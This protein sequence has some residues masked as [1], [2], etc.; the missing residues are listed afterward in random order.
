[1]QDDHGYFDYRSRGDALVDEYQGVE[2]PRGHGAEARV[3]A[4]PQV[5]AG[6]RLFGLALVSILVLLS[7]VARAQI[8]GSEPG[9]HVTGT[10]VVYGEPDTAMLNI[11]VSTVAEDVKVAMATSDETMNAV[12][13]AVIAAGVAEEDIVTAGLNVWREELTD[14]EGNPT[15][16][17]YRVSHS[18]RLTV[19]AVDSVGDVLAA[20]VDAGA[21]EVG[22]ISF[23]LSDPGALA[24][25]AR[26]LA[27]ADA[28]ERATGLAEA[29]GVGLGA[30]TSITEF[31]AQPVAAYRQA[32]M[33]DAGG[34]AVASGQLAITVT[35]QVSY[36][37]TGA[38]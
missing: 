16:T 12:R 25:Q 15:G 31:G 27:L 13:Q 21:N 24:A 32:A 29:A 7:G 30:P 22:G 10:G 1:M 6:R 17:R 14:R 35:V 18:Y 2:Y 23:T 26:E 4:L 28:R 8:G 37:L 34:S 5:T 9:I 38:Q 11:G 20:A 19:R 36:A 33:M 3:M